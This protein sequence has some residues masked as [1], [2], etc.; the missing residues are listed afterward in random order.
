MDSA[1]DAA[2]RGRWSAAEEKK[3]KVYL[4]EDASVCVEAATALLNRQTLPREITR[5]ILGS[6]LLKKDFRPLP[7]IAGL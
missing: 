7:S 2:R 6:A 4:Q 5:Q 1:S 3:S